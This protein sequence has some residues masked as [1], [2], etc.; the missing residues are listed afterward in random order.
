[1]S[2]CSS[3]AFKSASPPYS[4]SPTTS[5]SGSSSSIAE[6]NSRNGALSSTI[7]IVFF[8][9]FQQ[10]VTCIKSYVY[11]LR[12]EP[13]CVNQENTDLYGKR[14][15]VFFRGW[16]LRFGISDLGFEI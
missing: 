1:M 16:D 6:S 10:L 11:N 9:K 12:F 4:A 8:I 7:S 5:I 14:D 2:G 3:F 15:V 13:I